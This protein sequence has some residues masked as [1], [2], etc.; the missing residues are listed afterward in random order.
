MSEV[1]YA[2]AMMPTHV[3]AW[4]S[5]LAARHGCRWSGPGIQVF[6]SYVYG[7]L[8]RKGAGVS[9]PHWLPIVTVTRWPV[10]QLVLRDVDIEF[11]ACA[12]W[13]C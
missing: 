12:G 1:N 10:A 9:R 2:V 8:S 4:F 6:Q 3:A 5:L 7:V 13:W 11:C